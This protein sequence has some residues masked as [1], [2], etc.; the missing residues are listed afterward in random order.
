M[1][2]YEENRHLIRTGDVGL[3]VGKSLLSKSIQ[4]FDNTKFNH[5]LI[6]FES[7]GR[8]FVVD[9]NAPGVH[10]E[11]L[12]SRMNKYIDFRILRPKR[13]E[14]KIISALKLLLTPENPIE[15]DFQL[16]LRIGIIRKT[17]LNLTGLGSK[18]KD[19]CSEYFRK[20]SDIL[21]MKEYNYEKL[22]LITPGDIDRYLNPEN[23]EII[24]R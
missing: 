3:M 6:I 14:G 22:P 4:Y 1:K 7:F 9:S 10:P 13:P 8:K 2:K 24:I 12:S 11:F 19:I 21:E 17:G 5:V 20:Y 18:E 23:M 15:Y 16:L